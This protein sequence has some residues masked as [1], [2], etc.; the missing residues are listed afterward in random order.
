[1]MGEEEREKGRKGDRDRWREERGLGNA[2]ILTWRPYD[3]EANFSRTVRGNS[4]NSLNRVSPIKQ[5]RLTIIITANKPLA[6]WSLAICS[7]SF[8]AF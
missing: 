2:I 3:A 5:T 6:A 7:T 4:A 1:M 8:H